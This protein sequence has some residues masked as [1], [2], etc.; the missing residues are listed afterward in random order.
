MQKWL[1]T[2]ASGLLGSNLVKTLGSQIRA[3]SVARKKAS[4]S[5]DELVEFDLLNVQQINSLVSRVRP[6]V[7]LHAAALSSHEACQ[8]N[9]ALARRLNIDVTRALAEAAEDHGSKLI[10]I[11]TD[12]VFD[13]AK[14]GYTEDSETNP[15][16]VYGETKLS[17]EIAALTSCQE[18]LV[19]RTN[20]FGWSPDGNR[21]ILE[22]FYNKLTLKEECNGYKDFITTSI[23]APQLA[24]TIFEL[25][26][27][28]A[29]G[30]LNCT[31]SNGL[32]K[33]EFALEVA[34][35]FGLEK[36]YVLPALAS[37]GSH[38]IHRSRDLSLVTEKVSLLLGRVMDTQDKGIRQ[39]LFDL[40][41][42]THLSVLT[43]ERV[44]QNLYPS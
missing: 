33:Y 15:F 24:T 6:D 32:S 1:I 43:S 7:I 19:L 11:S 18:A 10:Y 37:R 22:F 8:E 9:P 3:I 30:I 4:I 21:S 17:G 23:Y 26:K 5:G 41:K 29:R 42:Q 44:P 35:V 34:Q 40:S 12:A 36:R 27:A 2:G 25:D 28:G 39:A 14:G 38:S 20:F 13:G 31:A 16:S